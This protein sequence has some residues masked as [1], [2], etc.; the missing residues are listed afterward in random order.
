MQKYDLSGDNGN[1]GVLGSGSYGIVI[2]GVNKETGEQVAIKRFHE[3][4]EEHLV[5]KTSMREVKILRALRGEFFVVNLIEAF[6][7]KGKLYLVFNFVGKN[8]LE[9]LEERPNGLTEPEVRRMIYTAL[10]AI[11][12]CHVNGV[13]HRDLKVENLLVNAGDGTLRLCDFGFARFLNSLQHQDGTTAPASSSS[14]SAGAAQGVAATAGHPQDLT[15]YV[16]TRW[17]RAPE[18]LLGTTNYG[19]AVDMW[20]LGCIMAE[21]IDGQP[22][23]PA[24]NEL[25]ML[26]L[27]GKGLGPLTEHQ[28]EVF[29]RTPRFKGNTLNR[30]VRSERLLERKFEGRISKAAMQVLKALV[31]VDPARRPTVV[32][33]L[34]MPWFDGLA[35]QYCP[36]NF[37]LGAPSIV[38]QPRV[39]SSGTQ[40]DQ[41]QQSAPAAMAGDA[42]PASGIT[43][44]THPE[45]GVISRGANFPTQQH[46]QH[47]QPLPE[48][49]VNYYQQQLQIGQ[50]VPA[51]LSGG[52][53]SNSVV[54][55]DIR[56]PPASSVVMGNI[57]HTL[58]G[59]AAAAAA[60]RI[61]AGG[62]PLPLPYPH[63]AGAGLPRQQ[64]TLA[65]HQVPQQAPTVVQVS[66]ATASSVPA[67]GVPPRAG[68]G[69]SGKQRAPALAG[70]QLANPMRMVAGGGLD[71]A[72]SHPHYQ[73]QH[74]QQ[75]HA[76]MMHHPAMT[77]PT[78]SA[79]Q[80]F[81]PNHMTHSHYQ[82]PMPMQQQQQPMMPFS[83]ASAYESIGG[84]MTLPK[85]NPVA[86]SG[87]GNNTQFVNGGAP[88]QPING[89]RPFSR[90]Q[91]QQY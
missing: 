37:R 22:L 11:H 23:F 77:T 60:A 48:S 63:P 57:N 73:L 36:K 2:K 45:S 15:D 49:S 1:G 40:R 6:R 31:D 5:Q 51:L 27:I 84:G 26:R 66:T 13:I 82:Q 9:L 29:D 46:H 10:L 90:G 91:Q 12:S 3:S 70:P 30:N 56:A 7:R 33:A 38:Q 65:Q 42:R 85:I 68:S 28:Y 64:S 75:Q 44:P 8:L 25:D 54:M 43:T 81:A 35:Q 4:E 53:G 71:Y 87:T 67:V 41:Q 62:A 59:A 34:Q 76:M 39:S 79:T 80:Q 69:Q 14:S 19:F 72:M 17:Y 88:P 74:Q 24:E 78:T 16:A 86:S 21:I 83:G 50:P 58:T 55:P 32:Q 20:A 61:P 89:G 52:G 18:L 47:H